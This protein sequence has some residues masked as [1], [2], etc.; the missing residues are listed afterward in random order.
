MTDEEIIIQIP[1]A[2]SLVDIF[3]EW[4]SFHDAEVLSLTLNRT[5]ASVME[6]HTFRMTKEVDATGHYICDRHIIVTFELGEILEMNVDGFNNQNVVSGLDIEKREDG[7][8]LILHPCY[9]LSGTI[10]TDSIA[11]TL[12][13]GLPPGSVYSKQ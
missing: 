10:L 6:V 11:I 4:P 13:E 2:K 9:G 7:M 12:K 3:G 1:G 5:G 8:E